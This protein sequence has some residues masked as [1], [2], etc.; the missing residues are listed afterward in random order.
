MGKWLYRKIRAF[1]GELR[2]RKPKR[3]RPD[4]EV[5]VVV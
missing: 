4:S 5:S 1:V 3:P 2:Q